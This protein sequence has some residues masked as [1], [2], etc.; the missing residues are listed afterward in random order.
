MLDVARKKT[1]S[2]GLANVEYRVGDAE[3]LPFEEASFDVV[4]SALGIFFLSDMLKALHEWCRVLKTGGT[5]AFSS[6]GKDFGHPLMNLFN[7]RLAR[8]EGQTPTAQQ[9]RERVD[10]PDRCRELLKRAGVGEI[11]VITE[12]LGGYVQDTA[13]IWREINSMINK[14]RLDRLG[15][16]LTEKFKVEYFNEIESLRT[17]QGIWIDSTILFSTAKKQQ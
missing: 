12:Q 15:P 3:A 14:L 4:I 1:A 17:K 8:Y 2:A 5:I 6:I 9:P 16:A 13:D 7:E 11:E 10:I